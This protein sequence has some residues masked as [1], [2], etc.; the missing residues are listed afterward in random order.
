MK[1]L[2]GWASLQSR[3]LTGGI[4]FLSNLFSL[5]VDMLTK[6]RFS[7]KGLFE[8]CNISADTASSSLWI[9]GVLQACM[10]DIFFACLH[11]ISQMS[12]DCTSMF[13]CNQVPFYSCFSRSLCVFIDC[14]FGGLI[15]RDAPK[16]IAEL[17]GTD[18]PP[19][20]DG[21]LCIWQVS[22]HMQ[23]TTGSLLW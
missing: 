15:H 9:L 3:F 18:K 6:L 11:H 12:R 17:I 4:T 2:C 20:W 1:F 14:Y 19:F 23:R 7:E 16:W 21:H 8:H 5:A 13:S 22:C 10:A